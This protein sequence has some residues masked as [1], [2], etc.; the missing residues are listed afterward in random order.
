MDSTSR[1]KGVRTRVYHITFY[2]HDNSA[3][4]QFLGCNLSCLGCIRKRYLWDHHIENIDQAIDAKTAIR[5]LTLGEL[6]DILRK[7]V[8][9]LGLRRAVLGGGEPTSDPSF[10]Q[11]IEIL[12]ELGLSISILTNGY[13]LDRVLGC[14][15]PKTLIELSIKSIDSTKYS[16]YTGGG[17]LNK[18]LKNFEMLLNTQLN[19]VVETI[20]IP[21]FNDVD[22]IEKLAMYIAGKDP[23]IPLIIDEYIPV[24][25]TPWGRPSRESLLDAYRRARKYLHIVI[26]R[27]SYPEFHTSKKLGNTL[28]LYPSSQIR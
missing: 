4:I 26:V 8:D 22:D 19:V 21:Q 7:A 27:S 20:L 12:G 24:P 18:V 3:Y 9:V 17:D 14:I 2:D 11:I 1:D 16:L 13:E 25:Q 5:T 15:P 6:E 23:G 10:C 28:I